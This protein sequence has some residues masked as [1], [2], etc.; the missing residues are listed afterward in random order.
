[1]LPLLSNPCTCAFQLTGVSHERDPL[2]QWKFM[3]AF[4]LYLRDTAG[5]GLWTYL[6]PFLFIVIFI[7]VLFP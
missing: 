1:M 5:N 3:A 2:R 6:T 7:I 4:S